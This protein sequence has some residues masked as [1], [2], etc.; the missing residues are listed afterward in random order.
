MIGMIITGH[1]EFAPGIAHALEMTAGKQ[2]FMLAVPFMD[3]QDLSEFEQSLLVSASKLKGSVEGVVFFTDMLGGTPFRS[4]MLASAQ[5]ENSAVVVGSN[6]PM[7][8]EMALTRGGFDNAK[9]LAAAAKQAG[10]S[11][12]D[13]PEL[14]S[15]HKEETDEGGI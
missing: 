1:G 4:S 7:L 8:I 5:T 6:L 9:E 2:D 11:S 3:G 15:G 14:P 10:L 12:I 13:A